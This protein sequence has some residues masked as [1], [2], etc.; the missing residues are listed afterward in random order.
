MNGI[1]EQCMGTHNN[2]CVCLLFIFNVCI[3]VSLSFRNRTGKLLPYTLLHSNR[4]T[5]SYMVNTY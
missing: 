4:K 5:N 1:C 2:A 3:P